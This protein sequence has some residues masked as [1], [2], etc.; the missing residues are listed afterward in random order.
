MSLTNLHIQNVRNI[1]QIKLDFHPKFNFFFGPNGCGKTSLLESIYLLSTGHSFRTREIA[2]LIRYGEQALVING[3]THRSVSISIQK[4]ITKPTQ[5]RLNQKICRKSSELAHLLPCQVLYQ[6]M[7]DIIDTGPST[8]RRLLDWGLFHVKQSYHA[9]WE[10]YR[11]VLKQRNVLLRQKAN[12]NA[13]APWDK[14]LH[15]LSILLDEMRQEYFNEWSLRFLTFLTKLTDVA[16]TIQ[17]HKGWDKKNDGKDLATILTEQFYADL[18][19]QYTGSGP[20][21]ADIAVN[22][23]SINAKQALSRGQQKI[24]L[25]A[26]KLAQAS[27][28]EKKCIYL[29]DDI[30]AELDKRHVERF[31]NCLSECEG[32][33][34]FTALDSDSLKSYLDPTQAFSYNFLD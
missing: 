29:L 31:F 32:Q 22:S 15:E 24:I 3:N 20:H 19:R 17:Y 4:S 26:L 2:P 6:D 10:D 33:F 27:M 28:L 25:I 12:V 9:V 8:R 13:F 14:Q 16:C 30:T 7:F 11:Q 1:C 5:V 34:F 21:Q 23:L 18:Q